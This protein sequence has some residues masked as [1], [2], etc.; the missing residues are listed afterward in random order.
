MKETFE[1]DLKP[2]ALVHHTDG[3][4]SWLNKDSN[5]FGLPFI[6]ERDKGAKRPAKRRKI[7]KISEIHVPA[8]YEL[9]RISRT[10]YIEYTGNEAQVGEARCFGE[11]M[12]V[13]A[14]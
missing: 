4:G 8:R 10:A 12:F 5:L 14:K 11:G 3:E 7:K 6:S 13:A 2:I 9:L 1:V